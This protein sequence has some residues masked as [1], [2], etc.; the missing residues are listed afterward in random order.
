MTSQLDSWL[1]RPV[2]TGAS[3]PN[4]ALSRINQVEEKLLD[5]QTRVTPA[6]PEHLRRPRSYEAVE[7]LVIVAKKEE[8]R[9]LCWT[10]ACVVYTSAWFAGSK[11]FW[12]CE[13]V[14]VIWEKK[15]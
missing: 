12:I 7:N 8:F 6:L 11:G 13:I 9:C 14:K 3:T 15:T 5:R 1:S 4:M 2:Y 10:S